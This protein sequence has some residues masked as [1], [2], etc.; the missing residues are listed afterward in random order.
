MLLVFCWHKRLILE[1]SPA[2]GTRLPLWQLEGQN[3]VRLQALDVLHLD[4]IRS[5]TKR[6]VGCGLKTAKLNLSAAIWAF[7]HAVVIFHIAVYSFLK[8]VTYV[9]NT[10]FN[11]ARRIAI[12]A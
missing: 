9:R 8:K 7:V 11:V 5:A 3:A 1:P 10:L 2:I 4:N 12:C 6:T